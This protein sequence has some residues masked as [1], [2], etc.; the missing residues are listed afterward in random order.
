MTANNKLKPCLPESLI[1]KTRVNLD[2]VS[3]TILQ[4]NCTAK[5]QLY[6][7]KKNNFKELILKIDSRE[8]H[9]KNKMTTYKGSTWAGVTHIYIYWFLSEDK[10]N[11]QTSGENPYL[12]CWKTQTRISNSY[13]S[14]GTEVTQ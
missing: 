11:K 10:E 7:K 13:T 14:T 6:I 8:F 4:R 1:T 9:Q 3:V 12:L 5:T 2:T